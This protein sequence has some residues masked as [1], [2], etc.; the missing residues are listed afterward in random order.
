MQLTYT[1]RVN[2]QIVAKAEYMGIAAT[3]AAAFKGEKEVKIIDNIYKRVAF[4][5]HGK[6][7]AFGEIYN[8]LIEKQEQFRKDYAAKSAAALDRA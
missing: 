5:N 1:I 7:Q 8:I 6:A 2:N 4:N 3:I